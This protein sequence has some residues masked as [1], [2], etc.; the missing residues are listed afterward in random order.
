MPVPTTRDASVT[1][2]A[3]LYL[4]RDSA[5][6]NFRPLKNVESFAKR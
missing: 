6:M 1:E 4:L 2:G 3:E 5:P